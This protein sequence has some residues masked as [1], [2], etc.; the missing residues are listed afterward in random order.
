MLEVL[1]KARALVEAGWTQGAYGRTEGGSDRGL[2]VA[3]CFCTAGAIFKAK[4]KLSCNG[5][6]IGPEIDALGF[7]Y[8]GD[9]LV[10]NDAGY[11]TKEHVLAR[12]DAAIQR[13]E[14]KC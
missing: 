8:L 13:E 4:G 2:V 12:F 10:W 5:G 11:R 9:L 7:D 1:I 6:E 3:T 14:G